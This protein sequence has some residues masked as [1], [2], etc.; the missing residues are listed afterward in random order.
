MP[1]THGAVMRR[2]SSCFRACL[3]IPNGMQHLSC[4]VPHGMMLISRRNP[5]RRPA[6]LLAFGGSAIPPQAPSRTGHLCLPVHVDSWPTEVGTLSDIR[7]ASLR[8]F[9]RQKPP[10]S[11]RLQ[12]L[13]IASQCWRK[14]TRP[15]C[16]VH[17]YLEGACVYQVL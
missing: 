10:R 4:S 7:E 17:R 6:R 1:S 3:T 13:L 9:G 11:S 12:A 2:Y 15:R 5:R 8:G 14:D 16:K